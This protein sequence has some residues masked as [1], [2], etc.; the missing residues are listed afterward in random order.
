GTYPLEFLHTD[1]QK[2][3]VG[4]PKPT[5]KIVYEEHVCH[6]G[7]FVKCHEVGL[8][9]LKLVRVVGDVLTAFK[10]DSGVASLE[11]L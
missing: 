5:Q 11:L 2:M 10:S 9:F 1:L 7:V 8:G 3:V 4:G 6:F